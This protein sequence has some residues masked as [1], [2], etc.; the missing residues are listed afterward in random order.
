M[1]FSCVLKKS[2]VIGIGWN[3]ITL[4]KKKYKKLPVFKK[5]ILGSTGVNVMILEL[6]ILL[7]EVTNV[8]SPFWATAKFLIKFLACWLYFH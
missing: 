2:F 6:N 7:D 1:A 4:I 8:I 3:F 5:C